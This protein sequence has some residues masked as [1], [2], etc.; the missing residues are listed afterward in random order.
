M[1]TISTTLFILAA[2]LLSACNK[3]TGSVQ[4]DHAKQA[5]PKHTMKPHA[6]VKVSYSLESR[7]AAVNDTLA[8]D[9][10]ITAAADAEAMDA[11]VTSLNPNLAIVDAD[12]RFSLGPQTPNQQNSIRVHVSPRA[13]GLFYVNVAVSLS[14]NGK[15]QSRSV[16]IPVQV[17]KANP[18]QSMKPA[19]V[20]ESDNGERII[21]VPARALPAN[22]VQE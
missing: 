5:V 18:A 8:I 7:V 1:R 9:I 21:S 3:E 13:E 11:V 15:T 12:N 14:Q 2:V 22:P 19:G 17:G 20:V 10:V 16:A 4:L 6:P